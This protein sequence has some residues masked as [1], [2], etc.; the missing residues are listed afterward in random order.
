MPHY[1]D[2]NTSHVDVKPWI[3]HFEEQAASGVAVRSPVNRHYIVVADSESGRDQP[4]LKVPNI[5]SPVQQVVQQAK[6][7]I[8]REEGG[9]TGSVPERKHKITPKDF[10]PRAG[11]KV[12]KSNTGRKRV[13][14]KD[15]FTK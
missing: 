5:V 3:R 11:G 2:G 4:S 9:D 10:L 15:I 14:H 12:G 1:L 8:K 6:E 13:L 7:D